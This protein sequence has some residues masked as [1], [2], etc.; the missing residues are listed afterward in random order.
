M[1]ERCIKLAG[2]ERLLENEVKLVF[3][4]SDKIGV[5]LIAFIRIIHLFHDDNS[6]Q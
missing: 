6:M 5:L 3:I 1:E 4:V 2:S